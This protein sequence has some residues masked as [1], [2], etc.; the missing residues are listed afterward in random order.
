MST[1]EIILAETPLALVAGMNDLPVELILKIIELDGY[2]NLWIIAQL[3]RYSNSIAMPFYFNQGPDPHHL[4]SVILHFDGEWTTLSSRCTILKA[5]AIK[6]GIVVDIL[7]ILSI[8]FHIQT[9]GKLVW[10]FTGL[11][12]ATSSRPSPDVELSKHYRRLTMF[13]GRLTRIDRIHL[14]FKG[15][16]LSSPHSS[17]ESRLDRW[18]V[19][20]TDLLN[21]CTEKFQTNTKGAEGFTMKGGLHMVLGYEV[22]RSRLEGVGAAVVSFVTPNVARRNATF[23]GSDWKITRLDGKPLSDVERNINLSPGARFVSGSTKRLKISYT[24][25]FHPLCEWTYQFIS[26]APLTSL[27][28]ENLNYHSD[29]WDIIVSWLTPVLQGL[30]DLTVRNS[31]FI[32]PGSLARLLQNLPHLKQC[33]VDIHLDIKQPQQVV[34]CNLPPNLNILVAQS[35]FLHFIRPNKGFQVREQ[36]FKKPGPLKRLRV[37]VSCKY[38]GCQHHQG[39]CQDHVKEILQTYSGVPCIILETQR[40]SENYYSRLFGVTEETF[41][42]IFSRLVKELVMSED[43]M[44]W[45]MNWERKGASHVFGM[46]K[47]LKVVIVGA[48]TRATGATNRTKSTR[49]HEWVDSEVFGLL[50]SACG[51]LETVRLEG[52]EQNMVPHDFR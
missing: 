45:M 3:S 41:S 40:A 22:E 31:D 44:R 32:Q 34:S 7:A 18:T 8:A 10:V 37:I 6:A 25:L 38:G 39:S 12:S 30:E 11:E 43:H 52:P 19:A 49:G 16:I 23:D 46:F 24:S 2:E 20:M 14:D 47:G 21:V 48:P 17:F 35:D 26:S 15:D 36:R 51:S 5:E 27:I 9:I 33:H 29:Y 50:K 13:L 4:D 1:N 28:L 42:D